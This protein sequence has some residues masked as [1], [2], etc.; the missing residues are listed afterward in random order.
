MLLPRSRIPTYGPPP[1]IGALLPFCRRL[2]RW[3]VIVATRVWRRCVFQIPRQC[4]G[5]ASR[6][7]SKPE[8]WT[9]IGFSEVLA[10]DAVPQRRTPEPCEPA[11]PR[12][13]EPCSFRDRVAPAMQQIQRSASASRCR[14]SPT[15]VTTPTVCIDPRSLSF[16]TTAGFMSTHTTR[17]QEGSM[18]PTP[19]LCSIDESINT[20]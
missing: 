15:S 3:R 19:M 6:T 11:H 2:L 8:Q 9:N 14:K 5:G 1:R 20:S 13:C 4:D 12:T 18:L 17:T 7:R 16:V 10:I